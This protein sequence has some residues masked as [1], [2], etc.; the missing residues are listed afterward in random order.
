MPGLNIHCGH[1]RGDPATAHSCWPLPEI[2]IKMTS[3]DSNLGSGALLFQGTQHNVF[4]KEY[5]TPVP[6][7][8]RYCQNF[9]LIRGKRRIASVGSWMPGS[10]EVQGRRRW[11]I[12]TFEHSQ[13]RA[14]RCWCCA[15]GPLWNFEPVSGN[16]ILID[17]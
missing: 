3:L 17:C 6:Y 1:D 8:L 13:S 5:K 11:R 7:D 9:A 12:V 4:S 10:G 2:I 14:R 16:L 15:A